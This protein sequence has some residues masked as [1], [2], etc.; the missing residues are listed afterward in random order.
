MTYI[1]RRSVWRSSTKLFCESTSTTKTSFK[2]EALH[3]ETLRTA[4]DMTLEIVVMK[5]QVVALQPCLGFLELL[6]KDNTFVHSYFSI[7]API[8]VTPRYFP[9][10]QMRSIILRVTERDCSYI[11]RN[12]MM[13]WI[14]HIVTLYVS[15]PQ[16]SP[17]SARVFDDREC[18]VYW[19]N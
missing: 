1:F 9:Y 15:N 6:L 17:H 7:C 3:S 11:V 8:D 12:L 19:G 2:W 14:R 4:L 5:W 10:G 13:S 18:P 16:Y